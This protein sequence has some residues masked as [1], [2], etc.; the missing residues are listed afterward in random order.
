MLYDEIVRGYLQAMGCFNFLSALVIIQLISHISF[1]TL[2][3]NVL[4]MNYIGAAVAMGFSSMVGL[5]LPL[6]YFKL[7]SSSKLQLYKFYFSE[8]VWINQNSIKV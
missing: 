3:I 5:I 8:I 1:L 4:E 2:F 7:I 6:V